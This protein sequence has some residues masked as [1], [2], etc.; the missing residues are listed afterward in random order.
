MMLEL[1][2]QICLTTKSYIVKNGQKINVEVCNS[3]I[4][5]LINS[6][7]S[8]N[9]SKNC[10]ISVTSSRNKQLKQSE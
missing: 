9:L 6:I 8:R 5:R 2:L 3:I 1:E 10:T 4:K 7:K